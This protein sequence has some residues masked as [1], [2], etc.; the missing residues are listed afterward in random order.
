[1]TDVPQGS[2]D[3]GIG[4]PDPESPPPDGR[5]KDRL[6]LGA[7]VVGLFVIAAILGFATAF[8]LVP[9]LVN[10]SP[11]VITPTPMATPTARPTATPSPSPSSSASPR[12][13]PA[14]PRPTGSTTYVVKRGDT[15][16]RIAAQFGISVQAIVDANGLSDPNHIVVGQRLV[17]PPPGASPT[18]APTTT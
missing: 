14:S 3:P 8:L 6:R 1:M 17:I 18:P 11:P 13:S 9:R 12:P 15:L 5:R 7:G 4:P 2:T 16:G 10:A